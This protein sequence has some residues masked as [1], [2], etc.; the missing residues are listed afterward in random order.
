MNPPAA[1]SRSL[2]VDALKAVAAQCIVLHHFAWY[3]PLS[4][5][6]AQ[7]GPAA[8][9]L[10]DGFAAYGRYAVA[11]FLVVGG[12]LSALTL[13]PQGLSFR[14][15]P[16]QL[17]FE[18]YLR[19]VVPFAVALL[20]AIACN[21]VARQWMEHESLGSTP[22]WQQLLA[23]LLLLHSLLG[24][25]SLSAGVWYVAIDFKLY[26]L[27]VLLIWLGQRFSCRHASAEFLSPA[28]VVIVA[29]VGLASLFHFNRDE[30][31]D[32]TPLYFFGA[33]SLGIAAAWAQRSGQRQ[34]LLAMLSAAGLALLVEFRDRLGVAAIAAILLSH[35]WTSASSRVSPLLA[36]LGR[37]SY[38]LFLVHFPVYQLVSAAFV[39]A[40]SSEPVH[41]L[42]G[43]GLAWLLSLAAADQ[44]HRH[45]EQPF[46]RWRKRRLS[47]CV[48]KSSAVSR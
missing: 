44:L 27:F 11:V 10:I 43:L 37:T 33:Y 30:G 14:L 2:P 26:V 40:G 3:G 39:R 7:L 47:V 48:G 35:P 41:G 19:L 13:P 25:E 18:R 8:D 21:L 32:V 6:A 15:A 24:V 23:H 29:L 42:Y 38:A 36:Y 16:A 34:L 5:Q 31:W 12:Y 4:E 46:Q 45:V 28:V 1:C 20:F 22:Q 9:G 17:G